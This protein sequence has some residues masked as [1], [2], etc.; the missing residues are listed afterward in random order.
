M[1]AGMQPVLSRVSCPPVSSGNETLWQVQ[2]G[3][4]ATRTDG[5]SVCGMSKWAVGGGTRVRRS[6]GASSVPTGRVCGCED[7]F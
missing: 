7:T 6:G 4:S 5:A 2:V 1:W 3:G